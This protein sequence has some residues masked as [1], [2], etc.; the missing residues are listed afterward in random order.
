MPVPD[1]CVETQSFAEH[2]V[3]ARAMGCCSKPAANCSCYYYGGLDLAVPYSLGINDVP[4]YASAPGKAIIQDQGGTGYGLNVRITTDDGELVILAHLSRTTIKNGQYVQAGEQVGWM[5]S[6]GNS[7]GKHVH[8]EIRVNGIPV[9]PRTKMSEAPAPPPPAEFKLPTIP[10]HQSVKTTGLI[11]KWLNVRAQ[12]KAIS[13]DLGDLKPGEPWEL[14][15][16]YTDQ[17]G[18]VWYA[19]RKDQLV[20]WAAAYFLGEVWL[21]VVE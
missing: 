4:V 20:G 17:Q 18:N 11:T 9:D 2:E 5:G 1:Y 8:W 12:P 7:T 6:T 14:L 10:A 19:V 13:A 16:Y 3:R 15:G 21:Q